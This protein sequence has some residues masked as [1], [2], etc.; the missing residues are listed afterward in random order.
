MTGGS[1]W[2]PRGGHPSGVPHLGPLG[3]TRRRFSGSVALTPEE[4]EQRALYAA[5]LEYEQDHV[6]VRWGQPPRGQRMVP[7]CGARAA[8]GC[9]GA[10]CCAV[11]TERAAGAPQDWP[12]Q[13][14]AR[15][16]RS[17]ADLSLVSGL[18][19]CLLR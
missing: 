17:P 2:G 3:G 6:S 19:S 7:G 18:F 9:C 8:C 5:V 11:P 16:K 14:K 1:Q 12:R 4:Q 15:L 10:G 13:W